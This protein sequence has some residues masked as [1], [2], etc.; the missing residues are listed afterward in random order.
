MASAPREGRTGERRPWEGPPQKQRQ[1]RTAV[2]HTASA[3]ASSCVA[4]NVTAEEA[5]TASPEPDCKTVELTER[6]ALETGRTEGE[7]G[8]GEQEATRADKRAH[9]GSRSDQRAAGGK[10]A[11]ATAAPMRRT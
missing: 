10:G 9:D 1:A 7:A 4:S 8:A 6:A 3:T 11:A 5:A 2:S